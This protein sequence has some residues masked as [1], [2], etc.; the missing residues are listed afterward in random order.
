[1][2]RL[3]LIFGLTLP[4]LL[5]SVAPAP[6]ADINAAQLATICGQRSGCDVV[7]THDAGKTTDGEPRLV[8]ELRLGLADKPDDAPDDAPDDGCRNDSG[9]DGGTEYWIFNGKEPPIRL[10][11]LCNDGYGASGVGEDQVEIENNRLTHTQY[12]GS[13]WR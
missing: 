1:M 8:V 9:R 10:L 2:P 5:A 4:I 12:G 13:S 7:G 6:A 3:A 11:D